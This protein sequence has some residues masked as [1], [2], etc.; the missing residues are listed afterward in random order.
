MDIELRPLRLGEILDR[1]FQLY[2]VRFALFLRIAGV[3]T[4]LELRSLKMSVLLTQD[5]IGVSWCFF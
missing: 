4:I 3:S 1:I 2:R 5:M